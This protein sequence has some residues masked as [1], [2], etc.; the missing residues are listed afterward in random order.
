MLIVVY[1]GR[2][3]VVGT[4]WSILSETLKRILAEE[5]ISEAALAPVSFPCPFDKAIWLLL[6]CSRT[7]YAAV[8]GL[9]KN[10]GQKY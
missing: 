3:F 4:C 1:L 9:K 10:P 7:P 8:C 6:M 2:W 5:T